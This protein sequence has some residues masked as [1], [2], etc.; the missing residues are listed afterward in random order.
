MANLQLLL[1]NEEQDLNGQNEVTIQWTDG[2]EFRY[3]ELFSEDLDTPDKRHDYV[4]AKVSTIRKNFDRAEAIKA[5]MFVASI[6]TPII[7]PTLLTSQAPLTD[8]EIIELQA[9]AKIRLEKM[10]E[11]QAERQALIDAKV[12]ELKAEGWQPE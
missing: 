10:Q 7:Q 2:K 6:T 11:E 5:K 9:K 3:N 8:E 1:I 12:A 4:M